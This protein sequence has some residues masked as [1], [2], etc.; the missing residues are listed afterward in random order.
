MMRGLVEAM[1]RSAEGIG[2]QIGESGET[3]G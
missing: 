2:A 3:V 1:K